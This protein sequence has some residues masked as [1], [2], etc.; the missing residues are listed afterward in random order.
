LTDDSLGEKIFK[1]KLSMIIKR[2]M[3][4]TYDT[5]RTFIWREKLADA[6]QVKFCFIDKYLNYIKQYVNYYAISHK[7]S[8]DE[9]NRKV[10]DTFE[11]GLVIHTRRKLYE[12]CE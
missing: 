8:K 4:I 7:I 11:E 3:T 12:S 10:W 1:E 5:K 6:K 2:I 9:Y